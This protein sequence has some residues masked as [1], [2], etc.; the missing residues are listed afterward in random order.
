MIGDRNARRWRRRLSLASAVVVLVGVRAAGAGVDEWSTNGPYCPRGTVVALAIDPTAPATLYAATDSHTGLHVS[1]DGGA[2]W[3][4]LL[5]NGERM[6][7]VAVDPA[8]PAR[9]Y[10]GQDRATVLR[11]A[12]GGA[13]WEGVSVGFTGPNAYVRALAIDPLAPSVIY[14]GLS[15][16]AA[17]S[18]RLFK[19]TDGGATWT[20]QLLLVDVFA[21]AI[22]P[23]TAGTVY[24]GTSAGVWKSTNGGANWSNVGSTVGF[25]FGLAIDP[26]VPSTIHAASHLGLFR[27][28][29]AGASW[30]RTNTSPANAVAVDPNNRSVVLAATN[31]AGVLRSGSGG[32]FWGAANNG[33]TNTTARALLFDPSQTSGS[34]AVS[35]TVYVATDG[36]VFKSVTAPPPSWSPLT[37]GRGCQ[38][39]AV[40][41]DPIDPTY[42]YAA[43]KWDGLFRSTDAGATWT[44]SIPNP[45]CFYPGRVQAVA[46]HPTS[47]STVYAAAG[48]CVSRSDDRGATWVSADVGASYSVT[49]LAIDPATPTTVYAARDGDTGPNAAKGGVVKSS[50]GGATWNEVVVGWPDPNLATFAL[51]V[52]PAAPATVYAGTEAGVFRS[53]DGA[54]TWSAMNAGLTTLIINGLTIDPGDPATVYAATNGGGLFRSTAGEA[55]IDVTGDLVNRQVRAVALDPLPPNALLVATYSGLFRSSDG[56]ASWVDAG[57]AI[58]TRSINH[59]AAPIGAPGTYY[60]ST[61]H[62]VYDK[63]LPPTPTPTATATGTGTE[64]ATPTGTASDTPTATF[65]DVPSATMTATPLASPT[66]T[67]TPIATPTDTATQQPTATP[68]PTPTLGL[69]C[70]AAAPLNECVAGGGSSRTDCALELLVH[71]PPPLDRRGVPRNRIDC[72]EGDACD[73]DPDL[74]NHLCRFDLRL[75]INNRDPRLPGCAASDVASLEVLRPSSRSADPADLANRL[76]LELAAGAGGFGVSVVRAG[77]TVFTGATNAEPDRCADPLPILVPLRQASGGRLLAG[78]RKLRLRSATS[79]ARTDTDVLSFRCRPSTC[80]NSLV[81]SDHESCDDGNRLNGDGCNQAC[82]L[83]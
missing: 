31:S 42:V 50:D 74:G 72:Y 49:A 30:T 22:D 23:V 33:L 52:D 29:N 17:T 57:Q 40:A 78:N 21:I 73:A 36:G 44:P 67:P 3:T 19:S 68:T 1:R 48:G 60:V 8:D 6:H 75:C 7:A 27:S 71:P 51:A 25:A 81:E 15:D 58:L 77:Q 47:P 10:V 65:T 80:G 13:T 2:T 62:G 45:T 56:G 83:E 41:V 38:T 63:R 59:I 69:S 24:A 9:I 32:L 35:T 61:E 20:P 39:N 14:A 26:V 18:N 4:S 66:G 16:N 11:S 37:V 82:R 55:W 28:T 5:H 12:D 54:T 43:T 34:P 76:A 79:L 53:T 64:T 46:V 70:A